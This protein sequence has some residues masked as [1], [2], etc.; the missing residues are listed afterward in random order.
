[1]FLAEGHVRCLV[2][3]ELCFAWK[4]YPDSNW[5]ACNVNMRCETT[6]KTQQK[7]NIFIDIILAAGAHAQ[8]ATFE[9]DAFYIK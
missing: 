7:C 1:M 4:I 2:W 5:H 9:F 6:M 3:L 8:W